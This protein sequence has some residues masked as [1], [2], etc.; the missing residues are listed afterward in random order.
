MWKC[1]FQLVHTYYIVFFIHGVLSER[2]AHAAAD[3]QATT[4]VSLKFD[5]QSKTQKTPVSMKN[6]SMCRELT[7][8]H[9]SRTEFEE[10]F[11]S[12]N[13]THTSDPKRFSPTSRRPLLQGLVAKPCSS[14]RQKGILGACSWHDDFLMLTFTFKLKKY[15]TNPTL[16]SKRQVGP[17]WCQ[18]WPCLFEHAARLPKPARTRHHNK[19]STKSIQPMQRICPTLF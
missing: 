4:K 1:S 16:P 19:I 18:S 8:E 12:R 3:Q 13:P 11:V 14:C 17:R 10:A 9:D 5:H 7:C 6:V 2:G 15:F